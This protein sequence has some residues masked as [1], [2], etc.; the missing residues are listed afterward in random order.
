MYN[1]K[2]IRQWDRI[3]MWQRST[4]RLM[5]TRAPSYSRLRKTLREGRFALFFFGRRFAA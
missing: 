5:A 2:I 1:L 4:R 3:S